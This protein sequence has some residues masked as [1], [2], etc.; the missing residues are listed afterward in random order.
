MG[1]SR[2]ENRPVSISF[3]VLLSPSGDHVP[4]HGFRLTPFVPHVTLCRNIQSWE[5]NVLDKA[6]QFMD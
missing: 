2:S 3:P 4:F 6:F 1:L 5:M